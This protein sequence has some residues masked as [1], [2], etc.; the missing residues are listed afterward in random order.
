MQETLAE[1]FPEAPAADRPRQRRWLVALVSVLAVIAGAAVSLARYTGTP[2]WKSVYAEDYPVYLIEALAHPWHSVFTAYAGY[3]QLVPRLI[4]QFVSFLP[5]ADA[6][7]AFAIIGALVTAG[8][9]VF[10]YFVSAGHVRGTLAR[11]L[12]ALSVLLLPNALLQLGNSGV[13]TPWYLEIALF[14]ALLWRPRSWTGLVAAAMIGFLTASSNITATVFVV[15]VAIRVVALPRVKEHAVTAG[16]LAGCLVQ[17]PYFLHSSSQSSSRLSHLATPGQTLGFYGHDVLLSA[18]GWHLSWLLRH[19]VDQNY[20]VLITGGLIAIG[21]VVALIT[22]TRRVRVFVV[23]ALAFGFIFA[24]FAATVTWWVTVNRVKFDAEPGARYTALPI[25][26]LT[27]A[28]IVAVDAKFG[29]RLSRTSLS[30]ESVPGI[31]ASLTLIAVLCV[32]W[33]PDFRYQAQRDET[34]LW[35]PIV[36]QWHQVCQHHPVAHYYKDGYADNTTFTI[37]CSRL[38]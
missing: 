38:R 31:V 33:I 20:G 30:R 6:A 11:V 23:T 13:N 27:A 34:P 25:L 17:L 3:E 8:V 1:L 36:T 15:L 28:A 21:T 10:V 16:W 14:W 37:P 12:L 29:P 18:F 2:S 5:L 7:A 19:W 35:A 9:A 22:G 24:A 32:G 4:G 26:L